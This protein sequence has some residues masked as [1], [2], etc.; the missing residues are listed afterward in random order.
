MRLSGIFAK[1]GIKARV[2]ILAILPAFV[3]TALLGY[4]LIS[5]R[6]LDNDNEFIERGELI[7]RQLALVS[8]FSLFTQNIE[9]LNN[10]VEKT[11]SDD[12]IIWASILDSQI[13]PITDT[14]VSPGM[15][16]DYV[17][18][19]SKAERRAK[20]VFLS[21]IGITNY[22]LS[23]FG[24]DELEQS[25]AE[26]NSEPLGWVLVKISNKRNLLK[27]QE[28]ISISITLIGLGL[29]FSLFIA[30]A[31]GQSITAP[32][33]N[34]RTAVEKLRYGRLSER[35]KRSSHG[36][37]GSLEEGINSMASS[38]EN[39]Q[40]ELQHKID[41]A[42]G[43]LQ[44]TVRE[45][46]DKNAKLKIAEKKAMQANEAKSEFLANMSHEIRTPM[47]TIIG[48]SQLALDEELGAKERNYLE[49]VHLSAEKLL[50]IINDILDFSKIEAGKLKV[51]E[52]DFEF[53]S[54]VT[55][56]KDV[57][58]Y[59][60][61][62]KSIN[63]FFELSPKIPSVLVGDPLRIAQVLINLGN[64]AIKF[65]KENGNIHINAEVE[66]DTPTKLTL[67]IAVRDT[68]IG[69]SEEQQK[70][71]FESFTQADA[72]T[73]RKFGGTGL[74]L[75]ISQHLVSLMGGEISVQSQVGIGST[76]RFTIVVRKQGV[77]PD[78]ANYDRTLLGKKILVI[79]GNE[80][81]RNNMLDVLQK[82]GFSVVTAASGIEALE[83]LS[84]KST[85]HPIDLVFVAANMPELDGLSTISDLRKLNSCEDTLIVLM[86]NAEQDKS[87][88]ELRP[89]L[90]ITDVLEKPITKDSI[91][92]CICQFS[93]NPKTIGDSSF[94][95]ESTADKEGL[96]NAHILLVEDNKLNQELVI[97]ILAKEDL[98]LTVVDSGTDALELLKTVSFDAI[99]MDCQMPGM[100]GY[101]TTKTL[102][103]RSN[104]T[105]VPVIA[106]TANAL[107]EDKEKA[108]DAGM[109]DYII[110]PL[111]ID[112]LMDT[113]TKWVSPRKSITENPL[114]KE[115]VS[116]TPQTPKT[117][118]QML[119]IPGVDTVGA[120]QGIRGDEGI[121]LKLLTGFRD[122]Y[123]DFGSVLQQHGESGELDEAKFQAHTLKGAAATIGAYRL[124]KAIENYEANQALP[125]QEIVELLEGIGLELQQLLNNLRKLK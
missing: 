116:D 65:T 51:E 99:L 57:I 38:L 85:P 110:K 44:L 76:F 71:I 89:E 3:M 96:R 49:K 31:V 11:E 6:L 84:K 95:I 69:I 7:A 117:H 92:D 4:H 50:N 46:I 121:Y 2:M 108:F 1:L 115:Q 62:E 64:N 35:V 33:T 91:V 97:E 77:F 40:H 36:E 43:E 63:L 26:P 55:H 66:E 19:L 59:K 87:L 104:I 123:A 90:K 5:T 86:A 61:Q 98:R 24:D 9:A 52:T 56:V 17:F 34:I 12:S 93:K 109:N 67:E 39:A 18:G 53:S 73:T 119:D 81:S 114:P 74:G 75:S 48:M 70:Q 122:Q 100:D 80:V 60:A 54:V 72:S 88:I 118:S 25:Q 94:P 124:V 103:Q 32:I 107:E 10:A 16:K 29:L 42:T 101:E 105:Q 20:G 13:S 106:L 83:K 79:D 27:Q 28:I 41:E 14:K 68:G 21:P 8:E 45:L 112:A 58:E 125:Q 23:D 82:L 30:L 37:L 113:L 111:R 120:L 47:N 22:S 15:I 102:R 78:I